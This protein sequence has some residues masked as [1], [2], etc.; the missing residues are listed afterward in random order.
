MFS[1]TVG[2]KVGPRITLPLQTQFQ[3]RRG[4]SANPSGSIGQDGTDIQ[5]SSVR[6]RVLLVRETL[7]IPR[8]KS[9]V[10]LTLPPA[11]GKYERENTN[12]TISWLKVFIMRNDS[13]SSW[14]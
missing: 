6:V 3:A 12:Q 4:A 10:I 13:K 5:D 2:E 14:S 7:I 8:K 1:P 9:V 11:G